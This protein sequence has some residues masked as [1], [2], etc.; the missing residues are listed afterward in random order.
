LR[1]EI[2][3]EI[4]FL[5]GKHNSGKTVFVGNYLKNEGLDRG[6][7]FNVKIL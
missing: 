4:H 5:I 3:M 7:L 2:K 6:L 1:G